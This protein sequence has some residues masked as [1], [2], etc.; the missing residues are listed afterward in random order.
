MATPYSLLLWKLLLVQCLSYNKLPELSSERSANYLRITANATY[1]KSLKYVERIEPTDKAT[2]PTGSASRNFILLLI[3]IF[4]ATFASSM[5]GASP[6]FF[7]VADFVKTQEATG[8]VFA[9]LVSVSSVAMIVANFIGG[10][11]SDKIGRKKVIALGS[12]ILA[13]SL[14]AYSIVPNILLM[15]VVNF[16]HAFSAAMFQ[17]AFQAMVADSSKV[18]SRGKAF[19]HFNL[20]WIGSTVPAPLV[21]G[22]LVDAIGLRFPFVLAA[23]ISLVALVA[24]LGLVE[25]SRKATTADTAIAESSIEKAVMPFAS[26]L[27]I[28]GV[29]GFFNGLLNGMMAPLIRIYTVFKL[30]VSPTELGL[31]F[32]LGSGLVT[33]LVQIPGGRL[34]DKV[35][36][37]PLMLFSLLG[38]PFVIAMAFTSSVIQ[39]ILAS[40]GLVAFGNLSAPAYSAWLMDLVSSAKRARTSGIIN[41]ITGT[42]MF[43]GPQLSNWIYE[44]QGNIV[45][46]FIATALP[47]ILQTPLILKLRETKTD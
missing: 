11:L 2:K 13:P 44:T 12:A 29:I 8:A 37:K 38:V 31:V 20:F 39:F 28:F 5:V 14:F 33:T 25:I 43:I 24:S 6:V 41:T 46:P 21:G 35:G 18:G 32:S 45:L 42:G 19:G 4:V 9:I 17:P 16:L 36:R 47:W 30:G 10:F 40:A 1:S 15:T 26:V 23:L 27:L 7:L 22:F 3:I 34:T